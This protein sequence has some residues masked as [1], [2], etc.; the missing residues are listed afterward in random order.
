MKFAP[1]YGECRYTYDIASMLIVAS[2]SQ[3]LMVSHTCETF[4]V[5]CFCQL[6]LSP[7]LTYSG[8]RL[9]IPFPRR[10]FRFMYDW[11]I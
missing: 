9:V 1:V 10:G 8:P 5:Y 7:S 11:T 2:F 6:V 3:R 4:G